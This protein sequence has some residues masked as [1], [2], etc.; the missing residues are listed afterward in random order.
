LAANNCPLA[1]T[2]V[3]N[4]DDGDEEG[5]ER[6][7]GENG[8]SSSHELAFHGIPPDSQADKRCVGLDGRL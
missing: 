4:D 6:Q 7:G 1:F 8:D 2:A 3:R 5:D